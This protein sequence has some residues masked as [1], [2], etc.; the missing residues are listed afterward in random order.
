MTDGF[1]QFTLESG[2]NRYQV[3]WS[4]RNDVSG[5]KSLIAARLM[6]DSS[7]Q[8]EIWICGVKLEKGS[9]ATDWR[10]E[11]ITHDE[12]QATGIDIEHKRIKVTADNF[13]IQNNSG[14][15]VTTVDEAGTLTGVMLRTMDE[16]QG[17]VEIK[18]GLIEVKNPNGVTNIKMGYNGSYM[19]LSYYDNDGTFLYDLGPWGLSGKDVSEE[20]WETSSK[21]G[22]LQL[23]GTTFSTVG[24]IVGNKQIMNTIFQYG[25]VYTKT[26]LYM[27]LAGRVNDTYL[28]GDYASTPEIARAA[29]GRW[30]MEQGN[31][32]TAQ[33]V[34]G[35]WAQDNPESFMIGSPMDTPPMD[36]T[37]YEDDYAEKVDF[38]RQWCSRNVYRFSNIGIV[39]PGSGTVYYG[40]MITT[41]AVYMNYDRVQMIQ[42]NRIDDDDTDTNGNIY[43]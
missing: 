36:Y 6:P 37:R 9:E 32:T 21:Y 25:H 33:A 29:N 16:G 31:V 40:S 2:W 12:L 41:T 39:Q 8:G 13:E 20:R 5:A 34:T 28:S 18:G 3:T 22:R 42:I 27:Y 10:S 26:P 23:T 17:H 11:T 15:T 7:A 30:F 1:V 19:V 43:L 35:M 38:S 14:E 4:T 24:D